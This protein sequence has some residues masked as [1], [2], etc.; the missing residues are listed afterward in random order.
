MPPF[1]DPASCAPISTPPAR[2]SVGVLACQSLC[3]RGE[4]VGATLLPELWFSM[5]RIRTARG[6]PPPDPTKQLPVERAPWLFLP[7]QTT[8]IRGTP[9]GAS[10]D[11]TRSV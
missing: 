1:P 9:A 3:L 6:A 5:E 8:L 7:D 11:V 10:A 2:A 4:E